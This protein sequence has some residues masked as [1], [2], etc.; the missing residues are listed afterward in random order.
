MKPRLFPRQETPANKV[1]RNVLE[2]TEIHGVNVHYEQL[3]ISVKN[4][5]GS[6]DQYFMTFQELLVI[7][8]EFDFKVEKKRTREWLHIDIDDWRVERFDQPR[9]Y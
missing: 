2:G 7:L 9:S 3:F 6:Y 4:D 8:N 5:D 1:Q